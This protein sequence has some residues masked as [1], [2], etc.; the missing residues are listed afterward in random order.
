MAV[1][2]NAVEVAIRARKR[3]QRDGARSD[4][5]YWEPPEPK[6]EEKPAKEPRKRP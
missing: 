5:A 3:S 6:A 4:F 1:E 2:R